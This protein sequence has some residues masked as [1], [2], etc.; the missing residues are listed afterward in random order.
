[1]NVLTRFYRDQSGAT[2]IEYGL[3]A[4]FIAL[5]IIGGINAIS[6]A[7]VAKYNAISGAVAKAM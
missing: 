5:V 2:A 3:L 7:N 6:A 1:M 4:G